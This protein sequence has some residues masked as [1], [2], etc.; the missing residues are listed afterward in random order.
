VATKKT[1]ATNETWSSSLHL[2]FRLLLPKRTPNLQP[3]LSADG[4][5]KSKLL[6]RLPY[7][8]ARAK[9][10]S[11]EAGP[12]PRRYRDGK[13]LYETIGLV[14]ENSGGDLHV[15]DLGKATLRWLN[16]IDEKNSII[17]GRHAA[18]ALAACQLRNPTGWGSQ[19][20]QSVEV[21]PFSFIWRAMLALDDCISSDE[22][23]RSLFRVQSK[24]ELSDAI[25]TIKSVRQGGSLDD[26]GAETVSGDKKDDR[27][28]PWMA[29]A[30]FGWTLISD[31]RGKGGRYCIMSRSR[32]LVRQ[33][34]SVHHKHRDFSSVEEYVSH[35]SRAAALP[36]DVR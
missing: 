29:M 13:Q 3:F 16:L 6:P 25:S 30:S 31:K 5:H 14:Y 33:A 32:E 34:A 10:K 20:D 2:S 4:L 18:Y 27:I 36:E 17:L 28:I 11:S 26:L 35:I 8:V 21:F 15:T 1:T 7:D 23:N 9:G 12:D 22:L 24:K 19:Y